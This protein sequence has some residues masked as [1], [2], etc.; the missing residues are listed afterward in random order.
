MKKLNHF[1]ILP[2]LAAIL[3]FQDN[4]LAAQNTE[5]TNSGTD[6]QF[7]Q[8]LPVKLDQVNSDIEES[9]PI[10]TADD[11]Q[12]YFMRTQVASKKKLSKSG[13]EIWV[14]NREGE[15]W[16]SPQKEK[17]NINDLANNAVIGTSADG[18]TIYLF[19]SLETRH[20]LAKGLAYISKDSTGKWG[21][22]KKLSIPGFEAGD[23]YYA[24]YVTPD[25]KTLLVSA[26]IDTMVYED[27]Y[28]SENID[29]NWTTL[30]SLGPTINTLSIETSPFITADKQTLYFSSAGHGGYG[31]TDL[32][33]STRTGD[34]WDE[35]NTPVNLGDKINSSAFDAY[36]VVSS[37]EKTAYFSS[38]RDG[39]YSDIY[40]VNLS[41]IV[42]RKETNDT[43]S[44]FVK[45]S[46]EGEVMSNR[47]IQVYANNGEL[48]E[49]LLTDEKGEFRYKRLSAAYYVID[50]IKVPSEDMIA[51][52]ATGNELKT[53]DDTSSAVLVDLNTL[54]TEDTTS[55]F[56]KLSLEGEVMSN[57]EIQVYA[58]NGE[59]LETLLTD[60]KGEFRYKRLSAAYYVIDGI[61]VPSE[62]MIAFV[63]TGNELKTIDDT[64]SAVLV[65]LNTLRTE[66]TTS[67]FVKLSLEGEV[68]S[69]REIQVYANNGE[70]LETLLTDEKGEFR[71]KR[72]SA[73]YYVIDGIKVP[74]EDMIAFVATG[75][76]LKTIDDT[77]SAVLVDL[78]TLRTE[79]TT[80]TFV[81]LSLEGEVMSNRE[82]QVY[83]NNGELLETLLTD[84]KGE[85]RYKRLSA[86]YYVIDGIK[87]PSEDMIAF[88]ATG[89]ELKTIDDTSSAVL[90]DLN[91]LRTE[92]T[93]S[94]FVKLSL[95]GEVMS[96]RE[97]QVYANNGELL[98]TLLTDEKGEFRYKRLSAAYYVI[99]GIKVPSEDMIAFIGNA[100]NGFANIT[101]SKKSTR[102]VGSE[103]GQEFIIYFDFD[104]SI[105]KPEEKIKLDE[106]IALS[107]QSSQLQVRLM[108]HT[109]Y[110]GSQQ[111]NLILSEKRIKAVSDY[112]VLN[113]SKLT[114]TNT[115]AIGELKPAEDN[116]TVI[117]RSM[118]RR[119]EIEIIN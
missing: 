102:A 109:D 62:D 45:L 108:G 2:F 55:T 19:N 14:A 7:N 56:V 23:G 34:G 104:K 27:L 39:N 113:S 97:I 75:N 9:M 32:F 25:E 33:K 38:N 8:L 35:W 103:I 24:F 83:A 114:I 3:F 21:Q 73:A 40:K 105:I 72:L 107:K 17:L 116:S 58:N 15:T 31:E 1:T 85:F 20:K 110:I 70:L 54:R 61:K 60:E 79:D 11:Q 48:L 94:T 51:F 16:S 37:D 96:N 98:E 44:T 46:L 67:T 43:T 82:I 99:D 52:V 69:N 84:E 66:D 115:E 77:S 90:V 18:N 93:T 29:G 78:N 36:L 89:N 91:T 57:R 76:E 42:D 92:D 49:T 5:P 53:I 50:G 41:K 95:E 117:G 12:L 101:N 10:I 63:A 6:K 80:S 71:Y 59:L 68:M 64:S 65:D 112:L 26:A 22:I 119:V 106:L 47:E 74:S 30:K 87:V 4:Q 100:N 118:N 28:V 111:Y 88:V 13:Q 81:K 86:A